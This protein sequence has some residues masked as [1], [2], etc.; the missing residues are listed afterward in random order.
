M[1][2]FASH[3]HRVRSFLDQKKRD[4]SSREFEAE[5]PPAWPPAG[6]RDIVL[7]PDLALELGHPDDASLCFTVWTKESD[8]V[9]DG[10]ITLI[11]PDIPE[12]GSGRL[13]LGKI[14]LVRMEHGGEDDVYERYRDMDFTRFSLSL[15]GYMLRAASRHMRE[16]SRISRDAVSGGFSFRTL[17]SALIH[18]MKAVD[19][20][21][22]AEVVFITQSSDDVMALKDTAVHADRL[23]QAMN[24]MAAEMV[25]DC[26]NCEYQDVCGDAS[27]MKALRETLARRKAG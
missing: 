7:V 27:E 26:G 4:G 10:F 24:K 17:G 19:G 23:V 3:I 20:I 21:I 2:I 11:G 14:V 16:W 9:R 15:K 22:A 25:E 1:T 5:I 8:L 12:T 13:P 6:P 18:A